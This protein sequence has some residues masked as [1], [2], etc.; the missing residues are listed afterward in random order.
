MVRFVVLFLLLISSSI[1]ADDL[2]ITEE[3]WQHIATAAEWLQGKRTAPPSSLSDPDL[4]ALFHL[5]ENLPICGTPIALDYAT[6]RHGTAAS[7][8]DSLGPRPTT[9]AESF[10]SPAGHFKVHY[11]RIGADAVYKANVITNPYGVPDYVLW[12]AV[13]ADSVYGNLMLLGY[14]RPLAD[15]GYPEGGD[16]RYDIY[17]RNLPTGVL[18][19]T[20]PDSTD[21]D[22]DSTQATSFMELDNDYS[23]H[24]KYKN[25]PRNVLRVTIAHEYFHAVQFGMDWREAGTFQVG[26]NTYFSRAW[27]EMSAVWI[28]EKLYD[29]INDYYGYLPTFFDSTKRSIE[30]FE[31]FSDLHPYASVVWPLFLTQHFSSDDMILEI[32]RRCGE[33]GAGHHFLEA[34]Q[35]VIDSISGGTENWATAFREFSLWNYFTGARADVAPNNIG[36]EERRNYPEI[37]ERGIGHHGFDSSMYRYPYPALPQL[38]TNPFRVEHNASSFIRLEQTRLFTNRYWTYFL[39]PDSISLDSSFVL[40]PALPYDRADSAFDVFL[41]YGPNGNNLPWGLNLIYQLD[42]I[43][44]SFVVDR[45]MLPVTGTANGAKIAALRPERYRSITMTLA[46]ASDFRLYSPEVLVNF[47]YIIRESSG[48]P[49]LAYASRLAAVMTPYPNPAVVSQMAEPELTFIFQ[50]PTGADTY[51]DNVRDSI[52]P[53]NVTVLNPKLVVDIFNIAGEY[54]T[55]IESVPAMFDE[56]GEY[57]IKWNMKNGAG[58]DVASGA[59]I[60]YARLF[61]TYRAEALLAEAKVK[62]A[63]IR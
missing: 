13:I 22:N 20:W 30:K 52:G 51:P 27:M 46:Q 12:T 43:P 58:R 34:T 7:L 56:L 10:D 26:P 45:V 60:A 23:Y 3:R 39:K 38:S 14:P 18:G 61:D 42:D 55:T 15:D 28:E 31:G 48:G 19:Q 16:A 8:Q 25:D 6:F 35:T 59:Y 17:L 41:R 11:T 24:P 49:D 40:D 9:L 5:D 47:A 50:I 36:Y 32:W 53:N 33:L 54:V 57:R 63:V 4:E 62:V 29:H 37:P 44:D 21:Y 1:F 2:R